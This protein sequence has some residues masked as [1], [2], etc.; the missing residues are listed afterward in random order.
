M[1]GAGTIGLLVTAIAAVTGAAQ[2]VTIDPQRKRRAHAERAHAVATTPEHAR[3]HVMAL[4]AGRG[5]DVVIECAGR[6]NAVRSAFD[7][8][9][10][11]GRIV[12][13]GT[14]TAAPTLLIREVVLREH[15]VFGSSAHV[16]DQDVAAA[17]ALLA[18]GVIDPRPLLS[19]TLPMSQALTGGFERLDRDPDAVKI[20]IDPQHY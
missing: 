6:S 1:V 20:M 18:R 8:C 17:V 3:E 11:G 4:T 14:G 12:L 5:A 15:Q 10:T 19:A 16:W 9:R 2:V 13:V 7:L